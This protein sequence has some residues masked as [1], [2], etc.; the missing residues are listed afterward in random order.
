MTLSP[1][2]ALMEA[3]RAKQEEREKERAAHQAH[4]EKGIRWLVADHWGPIAH[5]PHVSFETV[6][7][8]YR[9]APCPLCGMPRLCHHGNDKKHLRLYGGSS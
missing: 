1:V 5:E 8:M 2:A 6:L 3:Y 7:A 4:L 9:L